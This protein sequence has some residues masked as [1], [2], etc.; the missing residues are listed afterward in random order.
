MSW[1][2]IRRR[3]EE[4]FLAESLRG[5]IQYYA[6]SYSK[7]PDHEGRAAVRFDGE[8]ILTGN[9]FDLCK[10]HYQNEASLRTERPELSR[11][12]RWRAAGTAALRDGCFDQRSFYRAFEEFTTQ[13]IEDSLDSENAI[14]RMF[15]VLDRRVGKRRL[16]KLAE[17]FSEEPEWLQR[18]Y[19]IR[20]EAEGIR[21]TEAKPLS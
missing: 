16:V 20:F 14:V 18:F 2:G 21:I 5:R 9:Y 12:E 17:R 4:E 1:S 10:A 11:M 3:L 19:I 15:A 8:E 13:S 6:V 7:C